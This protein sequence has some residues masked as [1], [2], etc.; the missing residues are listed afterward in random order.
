ETHTVD[1]HLIF[2]SGNGQAIEGGTKTTDIHPG[3][4]V[5]VPAGTLHNFKNTGATPWIVATVYAPAEHKADTVHDTL[6]QG[7]KLEDEGKD[8]P[9]SWAK[10][11]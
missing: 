3:D 2:L 8:E 6:E 10:E 7:E 1:Q 11:K 9:P 4:L 5:I